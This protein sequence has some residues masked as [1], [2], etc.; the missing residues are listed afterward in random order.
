MDTL[1]TRSH[2]KSRFG[3]VMAAAG[4][5]IGLGNIW[6][7]P[8]ICGENGGGLFVLIYLA[9][10]ALVGLPIM[11]A[12]ILIGR[13]AQRSPVGAFRELSASG[14]PWL[15][16]GWLGV[17]SAFVILSFYSVVAG[18]ALHY[19]V[20]SARGTFSGMEPGA[21]R[22]AFGGVAGSG[23]ISS[24]WH[25]VF[26]I[27][28]TLMVMGGV[29]RGVERWNR[30]L[31]PVLMVMLAALLVK[32]VTMDGFGQGVAFVFKPHP[33][34]LSG[35][36]V[37]EALGHSF[38]TLSLGMGAMLTYGSYLRDSDD[39]MSSSALIAFFDTLIALM[40]CLILFPITFTFGMEA[41]A[42]PGLVFQNMSIA[43]TQMPGGRFWAT[44]FFMLISFA[45]LTSAI[46]LLEV[47]VSYFI[48][49]LKWSRVKASM[50]C[51]TSIFLLG[52]PSAL[53]S[54][55]AF[56]GKDGVGIWIAKIPLLS[57]GQAMGW[58]D[59][60]DHV[61]ANW[62]LPLGGLGI[63]LFMSWRVGRHAR[64]EAFRTGSRWGRCY[65]GW[66]YLLRF[67][68]PIAVLVVFL[69]AVGWLD[70]PT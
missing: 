58:F 55:V 34:G 33:E 21:I 13:T 4:S 28:V 41:A 24:A 46:S 62:M 22:D 36:A 63:A 18:W 25:L 11:I 65:W 64:E 61:S 60:F 1:T 67:V 45:A 39:V 6:K 10:I 37:L 30:I 9:C 23:S 48:D 31:M 54:Q 44:L 56:F 66:M 51:G 7:F 27:V 59:F 68:V 12:E 38:F 8:Y 26:M 2:W 16:V 14:S 3:F 15:G 32:A 40:A 70:F 42:G 35:A 17:A 57:G 47:A 20:L 69:H 5:A 43:F 52:I 50:V 53:S 19:I 49:E 29:Q